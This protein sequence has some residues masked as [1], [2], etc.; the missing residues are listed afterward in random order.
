MASAP[1]LFIIIMFSPIHFASRK[2][3][4]ISRCLCPVGGHCWITYYSLM[5]D[6][7][8]LQPCHA[9][10]SL[11]L[12]R[13]CGVSVWTVGCICCS[14]AQFVGSKY[15]FLEYAHG[16]LMSVGLWRVPNAALPPAVTLS[17]SFQGVGRNL[18]GLSLPFHQT[19]WHTA[20]STRVCL[21]EV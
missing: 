5:L 12:R 4:R 14:N 1:T 19:R 11:R 13:L 2:I 15:I 6:P 3:M 17:C 16:L 21:F 7:I 9:S 10:V 18:H 20:C 8:R